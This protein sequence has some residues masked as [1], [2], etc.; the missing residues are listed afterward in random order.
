M[1]GLIEIK[2]RINSIYSIIKVTKVMNMIAVSKF[3]KTK[4]IAHLANSYLKNYNT[5]ID[6]LIANVN[7]V[8]ILLKNG[9]KIKNIN[10]NNLINNKNKVMLLVFSSDKGFCGGINSV[11]FKQMIQFI[12]NQN[13]NN[14]HVSIVLIGKKINSFFKNSNKIN[15]LKELKYDINFNLIDKDIESES[16]NYQNI[17]NIGKKIFNLY[18]NKKEFDECYVLYSKFRNIITFE[19][20]IEKIL[21]T[22]RSSENLK[23]FSH[24][25]NENKVKTCNSNNSNI[26]LENNYDDILKLGMSFFFIL[27]INNVFLSNLLSIYSSR[28]KA[29]D[30]A[31][32]NGNDLKKVLILKYNKT[33]QAIIT[34]ELCDIVT[35]FEA[36]K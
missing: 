35:G 17:T 33:R 34:N 7:D 8:N 24:K 5:I 14:V 2:K 31:T 28:M 30:G 10:V 23:L 26:T 11:L 25:S 15:I 4:H 3:N 27:N 18:T 36:L 6:N 13:A 9:I 20:V 16:E 32:N 22:E 1:S 21:P 12:K 29:M 19:T